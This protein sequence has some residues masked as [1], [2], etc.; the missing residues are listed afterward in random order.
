M[1]SI[2]LRVSVPFCSLRKPYSRQFL[3]TER[4]TPPATVYGFLLSLVG[5]EDRNTHVGAKLALALLKRPSVSI[6]LRTK[7]RVKTRRS[8]LGL[9]SNRAPDYQEV[10]NDLDFVVWI[11][12]G[13]LSGL[14][15]T[16]I[17]DPSRINRFG[18]L[19]FGESRD[20]V[21]DVNICGNLERKGYWL[22]RDPEGHYPLPIW[23]DHVGSNKTRWGQFALQEGFLNE[24]PDEDKRWIVIAPPEK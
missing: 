8:G 13:P 6:L 2:C 23:V 10:L 3:E 14:I 11:A 21:N 9:G 19:S 20:M 22:T 17:N 15:E 12:D 24:P 5:E 16:A 4:L 18:G 1:T 7:W